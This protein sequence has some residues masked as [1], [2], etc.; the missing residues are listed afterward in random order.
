[1]ADNMIPNN[2]SF[3]LRISDPSTWVDTHG[4]Y[5]FS[6]ALSR[7]RN[8][9]FAENL[10]Q[11]TFL[12]A[13]VS[14]FSFSGRSSERTWMTGILKHKIVDQFR[15]NFREKPLTDL[16]VNDEQ[17]MDDFNSTPG[18]SGP[19]SR[20][21]MP[22]QESRLHSKEFWEMFYVSLNRLPGRM[23]RAFVMRELDDWSSDDICRELGISEANLWVMLHRGRARLRI[24]LEMSEFK[25]SI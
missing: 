23:A 6:F 11:D 10:V 16:K 14:R 24:L 17:S 20:D 18:G 22:E 25:A 21:W 19:K 7:V 9:E 2:K 4:D 13:L 15:K 8:R 1:M 3:P 12:A 5:L